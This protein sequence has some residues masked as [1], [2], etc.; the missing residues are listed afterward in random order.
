MT[1]A[2]ALALARGAAIPP[3]DADRTAL[4]AFV[5]D[6]ESEAAIQ[7][8]LADTMAG[9]QIRRGTA[10]T[11][12]RF[13][14][15]EATP[16][17]L[18]VDISGIEDPISALNELAAVCTPDVRVLVV[19][20]RSEVS[21][22]RELIRDLGV[23]EYIYKPLTR[24]NVSALFG[25]LVVPSTEKTVQRGSQIIVV[26]GA[27][28]GCGAT[29]LAVHLALQLE[30]TKGHIALL[31]LHL[32]G[33]TTAMMLATKVGNGLRVALEEP[34]RV[35]PL[36]VDRMAA[37]VQGRLRLIAAEEP[38]E[39]QPE[40]SPEGVMH[41]LDIL[42]QR[43]SHVVVDLPNPPSPYERQVLAAARIPIVVFGPDLAGVRDAEA[44]RKLITSVSPNSQP[45]LVLNRLG[46]PGGMK[47]PLI[48]EGLGRRPDV[49]VPDLPRHLPRA[50]N[51][52]QASGAAS[53]S[54]RKA[55]APLTREI[56]GMR[57]DTSARP[58]ILR[59]LLAR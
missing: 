23:D 10:R 59:W 12:A 18:L 1:P 22:Y 24:S 4:L 26:C 11:A 49:I 5:A 52:G 19:G 13:L 17:V 48:I 33:G 6:E 9:A 56:F 27:R 34:E 58:S 21:F 8:G 3:I 39:A 36:F 35:D 28:G 7:A 37:T 50:A 44:T 43:F 32:R 41:L 54:L 45:I 15:N 40:P 38:F 55:L 53:A 25:P 31:D 16:R 57:T 51:L 20:D 30:A 47:L 42:R 14:A 29:T 46:A 2:N